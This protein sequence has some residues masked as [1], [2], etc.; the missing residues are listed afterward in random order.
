[1][2]AL[3]LGDGATARE[4]LTRAAAELPETGAWHHLARLYIAMSSVRG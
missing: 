1:L 3:F 2:A 4:A